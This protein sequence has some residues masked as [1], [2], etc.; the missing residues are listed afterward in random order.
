MLVE[1]T[2]NGFIRELASSSPAPG[3]GSVAALSGAVAASLVVM[4]CNLTCGK[5]KYQDVTPE[6]EQVREKAYHLLKELI[7]LIDLDTQSFNQVMSAFKLP[8]ETD[9]EK[10][11]RSEAIQ[12]ATKGA[13]DIPL[14]VAQYCLEILELTPLVAEKGNENAISDLGVAAQ[15]AEAGI[16]GAV[17][18]VKINLGSIKDA[19]YKE[20]AEEKIK[21]YLTESQKLKLATMNLVHEKL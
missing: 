20:A 18:N 15:Q 4:V 16:Q 1:K 10:K 5:A 13:A 14:T 2:L 7:K 11:I 19:A 3:G 17:L 9:E 21:H 12:N 8:K 6:L